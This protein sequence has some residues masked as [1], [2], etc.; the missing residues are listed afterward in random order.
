MARKINSDKVRVVLDLEKVNS[1]VEVSGTLLYEIT[2][3]DITAKRSHSPQLSTS[4][5][6][7]IKKFA[8]ELLADI[9]AIAE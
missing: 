2:S 5:V 9:K 1:Q 3:D 7:A 8:N 6:T 4:Q